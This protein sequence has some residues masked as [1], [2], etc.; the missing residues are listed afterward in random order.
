VATPAPTATPTLRGTVAPEPSSSPIGSDGS[1]AGG[2][3]PR[4]G[5][6]A[7]DAPSGQALQVARV[8][9]ESAADAGVGVELLGLLDA[10]FVWFVPAA[11]VGVPGL[12][13][14]L[15]VALQ[16]IGAFAWIP[17]VR[18]MADPSDPRRRIRSAD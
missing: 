7:G 5:G 16:A 3:E 13:V 9:D 8:T 6:G 14:I 1:G 2:S 17:V 4:G 15:W 12:L 18:R 11:S 10:D